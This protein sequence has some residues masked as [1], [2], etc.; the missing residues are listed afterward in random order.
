MRHRIGLVAVIVAAA[1]LAGGCFSMGRK[2]DLNQVDNIQVGKTTKQQVINMLGSPTTVMRQS[3]GNTTL[4]YSYS[5]TQMDAV[6]FI[7]IIGLFFG[8]MDMQSQ[9][10]TIQIGPDGIVRDVSSMDGSM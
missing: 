6:N 9:T 10:V 5:K 1:V 4:M 7:P 8:G 3:G 2:V